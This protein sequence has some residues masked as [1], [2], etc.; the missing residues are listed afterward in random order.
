MTLTQIVDIL[1]ISEFLF[2]NAYYI[3]TYL[4]LAGMCPQLRRHVMMGTGTP[5]AEQVKVTVLPRA[6]MMDS[7]GGTVTVGGAWVQ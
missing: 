2:H 3:L 4:L 5:M 7:S 1:I 6:T